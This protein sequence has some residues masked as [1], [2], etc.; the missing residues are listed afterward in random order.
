M[1]I[2]RSRNTSPNWLPSLYAFSIGRRLT[3]TSARIDQRIDRV[4]VLDEIVA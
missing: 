1:P 2:G 3:G 4:A